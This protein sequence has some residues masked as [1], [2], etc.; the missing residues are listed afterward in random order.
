MATVIRRK[1]PDG[2][3]A[4][5]RLLLVL[6]LCWPVGCAGDHRPQ[7][8]VGPHVS[9]GLVRLGSRPLFGALV[10]DNSNSNGESHMTFAAMF[11]NVWCSGLSNRAAKGLYRSEERTSELQS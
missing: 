6:D 3:A 4:S 9:G 11:S 7:P 2:M 5:H 8:A 10:Q 1:P